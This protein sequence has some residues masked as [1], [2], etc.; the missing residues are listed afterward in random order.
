MKHSNSALIAAGSMALA[1]PRAIQAFRPRADASDPARILAQLQKDWSDMTAK[2]PETIKAQVDPLVTA[3]VE[4]MNAS[5]AA[6]QTELDQINLRARARD[7]NGGDADDRAA[8]P[9]A[10]AYASAFNGFF[11]KGDGADGLNALA[12][13]AA[14][15]T[16]ADV[17]GGYLVPFEV[18][19]AINRVVINVSAVRDLATVMSISGGS[20]KKQVSLGGAGSGWVGETEA[21]SETTSP[22]LAELEFTPGEIYA[23]P[24]ASQ[25]ILDDARV[26]IANW[27]AE[28][29]A[30]T[31]AEQEGA[32]FV[33]G[34]GYKRPRGIFDYDKVAN[35]SYAWGSLG[36]TVSGGASDF[37]ASTP[38]TALVDLMQSLK[39]A[40]RPGSSWL[41]N[42]ATVGRIRKFAATTGEPLWQPSVQ[43]GQPSTLLGYPVAEDDNVADIA[44]NSFPIAFGDFRR[45]YMIVDRVGIRVLR[46][47]YTAKPFV[48]FYTTKRV[49]GGV[50][51]FEAIKLL[52]ISA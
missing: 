47:P 10:R 31:F 11:R 41:M 4:A 15:T 48:K 25:Q 27:L 26:D 38:W 6:L 50:Q 12:V 23:E 45:G 17:D 3:Q 46:D 32:A 7:L 13:Q 35:A 24:R 34:N 42:R 33:T 28:E 1:Y 43:V 20:Y 19:Q 14:L 8:T 51:N 18:E 21:R 22:T 29:V 5:V 36:F 44:T 52:K 9:A 39:T 30:F 49:G 2:L 37:T 40:Y 16:F